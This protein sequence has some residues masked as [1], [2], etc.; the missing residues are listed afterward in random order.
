MYQRPHWERHFTG[1][2]YILTLEKA[3]CKNKSPVPHPLS[4]LT[5]GG[6]LMCFNSAEPS[7]SQLTWISSDS[8]AVSLNPM[9]QV[10]LSGGSIVYSYML[11]GIH[12][13][14][15]M[16]V[17]IEANKSHLVNVLLGIYHS[18]HHPFSST[19]NLLLL[20]RWSF[21]SA[22]NPTHSVFNP[23][24]SLSALAT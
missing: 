3:D 9:F 1:R 12:Y 7:G 4:N 6:D 8:I 15:L 14:R 10:I 17:L 23:I 21:P 16:H 22:K 11:F 24:C 20:V 2:P 5:G 13:I 19:L 18:I